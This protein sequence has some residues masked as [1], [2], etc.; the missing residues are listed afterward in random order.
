MRPNVM[1]QTA[2]PIVA[3]I[4]SDEAFIIHGA[5]VVVKGKLAHSI[6]RVLW[7]AESVW[8]IIIASA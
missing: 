4:V 3:Q 2:T 6:Q 5:Q 1:D 8:A 7:T